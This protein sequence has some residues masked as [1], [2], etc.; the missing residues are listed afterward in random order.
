MFS[1]LSSL[2]GLS[3]GNGGVTEGLKRLGGSGELRFWGDVGVKGSRTDWLVSSG[4][5]GG[6][7][8]NGIKE[9]AIVHWFAKES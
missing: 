9:S 7:G 6:S 4:S 2:G 8:G 3:G 1:V 5:A